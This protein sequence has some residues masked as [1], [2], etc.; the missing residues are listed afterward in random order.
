MAY[1]LTD[2]EKDA[3][4][5]RA[6]LNARLRERY[7]LARGLGFSPKE[8]KVL[9]AKKRETIVRLAKERGLGNAA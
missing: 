5:N 9:Q 3:E 6:R 2:L 1:G 8:A 7:A 4:I